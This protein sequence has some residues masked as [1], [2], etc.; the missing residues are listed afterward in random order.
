MNDKNYA[1]LHITVQRMTK[2]EKKI[3]INIA[4]T[5]CKNIFLYSNTKV[6]N[7]IFKFAYIGCK[8]F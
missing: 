8:D 7:I 5:Y 4:S 1:L 6:L 2:T 3:D